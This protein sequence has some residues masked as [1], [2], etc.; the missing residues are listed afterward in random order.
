MYRGKDLYQFASF[1]VAVNILSRSHHQCAFRNYS[2][3]FTVLLVCFLT[4]I[5]EL[6]LSFFNSNGMMPNPLRLVGKRF[7]APCHLAFFRKG[8]LIKHRK[9]IRLFQTCKP[10]KFQGV[11]SDRA[12]TNTPNILW[13]GS[14]TAQEIPS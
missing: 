12:F 13:H 3:C 1:S 7:W 10:L 2:F 4:V 8:L 5:S 14:E 11:R 6:E 9:K